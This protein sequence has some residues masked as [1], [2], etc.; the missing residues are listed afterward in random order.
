MHEVYILIDAD[1]PRQPWSF[2]VTQSAHFA[3]YAVVR[4][5]ALCPAAT[6]RGALLCSTLLAGDS[7]NQSMLCCALARCLGALGVALGGDPLEREPHGLLL[8]EHDVVGGIR[9]WYS[10]E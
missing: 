3:T 2:L 8:G 6:Y 10:D 9:R 1:T 4:T 7:A 5:S